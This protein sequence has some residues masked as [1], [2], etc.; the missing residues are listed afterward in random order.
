MRP[1]RRSLKAFAA[2][3]RNVEVMSIST[4]TLWRSLVEAIAPTAEAPCDS[5]DGPAGRS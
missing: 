1:R 5:A 4:T 3:A 2:S